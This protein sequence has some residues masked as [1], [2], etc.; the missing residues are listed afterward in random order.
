MFFFSLLIPLLFSGCDSISVERTNKP[1]S[2]TGTDG[3]GDGFVSGVDCDDT[4]S[5]IYPGAP[6]TL[7]DGVDSNCDSSDNS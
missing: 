6:E 7:D 4:D 3:D 1:D 2:D 5:A